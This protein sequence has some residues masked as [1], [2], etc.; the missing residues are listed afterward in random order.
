MNSEVE[1]AILELSDAILPAALRDAPMDYAV[2]TCHT[3][4][5]MNALPAGTRELVAAALP[6]VVRFAMGEA[7]KAL[8]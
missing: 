3:A 6:E 1:N 8:G 4:R 2:A 5:L 7:K